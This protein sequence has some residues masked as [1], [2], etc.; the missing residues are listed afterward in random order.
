MD[1]RDAEREVML[2]RQAADLSSRAENSARAE[3]GWKVLAFYRDLLGDDGN[4]DEV[5]ATDL[6]ADLMHTLDARGLDPLLPSKQA[7]RHFDAESGW[8]TFDERPQAVLAPSETGETQ[9]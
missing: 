3:R 7:F 2:Q 9:K 1:Q 4:E 6:I 5:V 8:S